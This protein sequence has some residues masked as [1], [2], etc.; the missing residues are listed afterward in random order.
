MRLT[1][2]GSFRPGP[3][4]E[5]VTVDG[6][7]LLDAGGAP[8]FVPPDATD[9]SLAT[10]GTLSADGRPLGLV[11]LFLPEDPLDMTR[12]GDLR[13]ATEGGV[14]PVEAPAIAQGFM[15]QSNVD[16]VIEV[17]RMIEVQRAYEQGSKFLDRKMTGSGQSSKS[18]DK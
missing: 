8:L 5:L 6:Y 9:V 10:D 1:R 12:T 4:G 17:A 13:F 15:E 18:L 3:A 16:P 2:A 7:P 14:L 11:G